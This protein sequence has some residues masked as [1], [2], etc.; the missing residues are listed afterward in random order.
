MTAPIFHMAAGA[1]TPVAP[2][3]HAVEADGWVFVTGQ[4]PNDPEDEAA[5][6][7]AGI[8]GQTRN[9]MANLKTVLA[10]LGLGLEHV[11]VARVYLTHFKEDY[12]AMNAVYET[13]FDPEQAP[14]AH[15]RRRHRTRPRCPRRDRPAGAAAVICRTGRIVISIS[16]IP[17]CLFYMLDLRDNVS[18]R[19]RY[20]CPRWAGRS[21]VAALRPIPGRRRTKPRCR[22]R[23]P[24]ASWALDRHAAPGPTPSEQVSPPLPS[25][26]RIVPYPRPPAPIMGCPPAGGR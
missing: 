10:S 12:A 2:F 22:G 19:C 14:G 17:F 7:P 1:P 5:P 24:F 8:E 11:V 23:P 9:V 18:F 15:L 21:V 20:P 13:Y 25:R 6:L 4:M 3:S 26:G 16:G